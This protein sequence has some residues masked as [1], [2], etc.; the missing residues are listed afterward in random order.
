MKPNI[1]RA[2]QIA[3]QRPG[4]A[5]IAWARVALV[6]LALWAAAGCSDDTSGAAG[7]QASSD[8]LATADVAV[9]D[10]VEEEDASPDAVALD[11]AGPDGGVCPGSA[12]C[13]CAGNKDCDSG[14]CIQTPEGKQCAKTCT[15][16][17]QDGFQCVPVPGQ[18]G[19]VVNICVPS[20]G[21]LCNPCLTSQDCQAIGLGPAACVS[22]G[23]AGNYCGVGCEA[24]AGCPTGFECKELATT[25][26]TKAKQC[27][28]KADNAGAMAACACSPA[29]AAAELS[30]TCMAPAKDASGATVGGCPGQRKCTKEGLSTCSAPAAAAEI[31]DG[32][33]ND[34]N[35]KTD[36]TACDDSNA[37]TQDLC[38]PGEDKK[39]TCQHKAVESSCDAD[40]NPCTE[41][42]ACKE[43][44]CVAGPAK[45]CEDNNP[46]TANTCDATLGCVKSDDNGAPCDDDNPCT[47]GDLCQ[48]GQ[49][50]PGQTKECVSTDD[51]Q[52]AKC[53]Q[54]DGKCQFSNKGNG[55]L[56]NDGTVC[57]NGDT[58]ADGTCTGT[59]VTC[60]DGKVCTNDAC[61]P[62]SGCTATDLT[63]SCS[64]GNACTTDDS[65][66][67]GNC[68]AGL[69][70]NCDD[71][72]ACTLDACDPASGVCSNSA[73]TGCGGNC[74]SSAD[75]NDSN[76]CTDDS[77]VAGKCSVLPN[78]AA[79][80]DGQKCTSADVCAKGQCG[81]APTVCDD[82]NPCTTDTCNPANGCEQAPNSVSCDDGNGCTIGDTCAAGSCQPGPL[83]V[84]NDNNPCTS[85]SCDPKTGKCLS[86]N[87]T[88]ACSDGD[89]CTTGD[90]C[91]EGL[92]KSGKATVCN[93]GKVCTD[94][95]CNPVTGA[96]VVSNNTAVCSD[97]NACTTGDI[98][99]AGVCK[100]GVAKV[101]DDKNPCTADSC[102]AATG[103]C[104]NAPIVGCG[105]N[106]QLTTDCDDKNPCTTDSCTAGKCAVAANTSPCS[107]NNGCTVGDICGG[108]T[109]KPGAAKVCDDANPCTDDS[110][111]AAT[112]TC[113]TANNTAVCNDNDAC[114]VGD[115]CAAGS[116]APGKLLSCDDGNPCTTGDVCKAGACVLGTPIICN[117]NNT[118]TND[119]CDKTTGKCAFA[120]NTLA[121]TDSN[122]CTTGDICASGACKPGT[123]K[124]CNDSNPCT[125]D[126]CDKVTGACTNAANALACTDNNACTASDLCLAGACK[127]GAA[128]D[129]DDKNPCTTDSCDKVTGACANVNNTLPC[130]D[131]SLCTGSDVCNGAGKC[132]G[133]LVVTCKATACMTNS[134]NPAT[135]QCDP[136]PQPNTTACDDLQACTVG[137]KC[138]GAGKCASGPWN[139]AC[140]CQT[141]AACNDNNPCTVDTCVATKCVFTIQSGAVCD[142]ADP[143]STASSCDA[144]GK[145]IA[146]TFYDCN[147]SKDQCNNAICANNAGQPVCKKVPVAAGTV[148]ND[149]LYC[150]VGEKCDAL[151]SCGGG[152]PPLCG[153]PAQCYSSLC[154]ELAK[155]CTTLPLAT[156]TPCTDNSL[157]TDGDICNAGKCAGKLKAS[158]TPVLTTFN[159]A[160]P[161]TST[162]TAA[163]GSGETSTLVS[164]Y[165]SN[166][167]S[168]TALNATGVTVVSSAFS[169]PFTAKSQ[170]CMA[171]SAK[172][173]DSAGTASACSNSLVFNHYSCTQCLCPASDWVRHFGTAKLD[174]A[175]DSSVDAAGN[176]YVVGST[177]GAFAGKTNAG[178]IDAVLAKLDSKG[179]VVWVQQFGTSLNDAAASVFVDASGFI[180]VAGHSAGD[181]DG[182]GPG[183]LPTAGQSDVF[184]AKY[185]ATGKQLQ[186]KTFGS[187]TRSES[188]ADMDFDKLN[189][190][191]LVLLASISSGGGGI[192]PQVLAVPLAT[193]IPA[194]LWAY[195]EDS[196]NKNPSSLVVDS[197]G[198][199]YVHGRSQ[200]GISGA[201]TTTGADN[202]GLYL[203]RVTG[204]GKTVWLQHWG[205]L[206]F[207]IGGG[208]AVDNLGV[209]YVTGYA[210][211]VAI[212]TPVGTKYLGS[213]GTSWGHGGDVVVAAF[214]VSNGAPKWV[215]QLGSAGGD[216]GFGLQYMAGKGGGLFVSGSTT[217]NMVTLASTSQYG[218][219]DL[220]VLK[221]TPTT[222][223]IISLHPYGTS[224]DDVGGRMSRGTGVVYIPGGFGAAYAGQ[225]ADGCAFAGIRDM[226]LARFCAGVAILPN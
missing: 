12:G 83:A 75:C 116:C 4:L 77:C 219:S 202:G 82:K 6:L 150:T 180:W 7:A 163:V 198:D 81:G 99:A 188:V 141:A 37:C 20:A 48:T 50:L 18:G 47:I 28:P 31:C 204:A 181:I 103:A 140:G 138:D 216:V 215:T 107:D 27:A 158:C 112:G 209:V 203:Y 161:S 182:A 194:Q 115:L 195:V 147:G 22:H 124:T 152:L 86:A 207:D 222:G 143:C 192:S 30:T 73:I 90:L 145:C 178:A 100:A 104:V 173:V 130:S 19:D 189:N 76:P 32:L 151:G 36:D 66:K 62:A 175:S 58:C 177:E 224:G 119:S 71:S 74:N 98:C 221:L 226:A 25:E 213:T 60:D 88:D 92:C 78:T 123:A 39:I 122:A 9:G 44:I 84:C 205:S 220:F 94:D 197:L 118:C 125:N 136:K 68:A 156:G 109:C 35:G 154:T 41:N 168:G 1:R 121:C 29:A 56:C 176:V 91:A 179:A 174:T 40:S 34:C 69:L 157:C 184:V 10:A 89:A 127:P 54:L 142:D 134:C 185:D 165:P 211:G 85:D 51:C 14:L 55:Q 170:S 183:P 26:G 210:Q 49:C 5:Q 190:R 45:S 208:V 164:L 155:G 114:T 72:D 167:C 61:D 128:K 79:C 105:G 42:D 223:G 63:G 133:S 96:C 21:K 8:S 97:S 160:S 111:D 24:D 93:D 23:N 95:K 166:N 132:V 162:A 206:A 159:P 38:A 120:N 80:D 135:G 33:D 137:D 214:A 43:G 146:K 126:S 87:T 3:L 169:V 67:D 172:A 217:G 65:C 13:T 52:V 131:G 108:G 144:G 187:T 193:G 57:T 113:K 17:C 153:K 225:S 186:I 16:T 53:N 64:D 201:L 148:C 106:C 15:T 200:W 196:Q 212:G 110:C 70:N 11:I 59:P 191:L 149:G 139:A 102:T 171:V 199:F 117:D 101:C 218:G 46:C 129:C 2:T